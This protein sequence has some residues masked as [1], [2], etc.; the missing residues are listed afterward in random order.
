MQRVLAQGDL[1]PMAGSQQA[2][3]DLRRILDERSQLYGRADAI[4]ETTG[5]T[6]RQ[7]V[8]ELLTQLPQY[9]GIIIP[10]LV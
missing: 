2:M 1:R 9:T 3:E 4:V 5:K 6:P 10:N 7:S 8:R